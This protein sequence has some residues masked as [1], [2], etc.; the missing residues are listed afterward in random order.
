MSKIT[1]ALIALLA[2]FPCRAESQE[3]ATDAGTYLAFQV[4]KEAKLKSGKPPQYPAALLSARITGEVLVQYIVDENGSPMM[5]SFKVLRSTHTKFAEAARQAVSRMSFYP[6][7]A[8]GKKVK[9]LVQ[10]P[11]KFQV[12]S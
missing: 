10:Q 6:A 9:Q 8:E 1:I 12:G 2:A 11:F 7:E 4:D 3:Q 5:D